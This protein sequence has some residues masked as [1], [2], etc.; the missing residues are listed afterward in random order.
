L[1]AVDTL[2][3]RTLTG[4][5]DDATFAAGLAPLR[6]AI[7][8][9]LAGWNVDRGLRTSDVYV[10]FA[11]AGTSSVGDAE[12]RRLEAIARAL[13]LPFTAPTIERLERVFATA[14]ASTGDAA[15]FHYVVE[16]DPAEGWADELSRWYDTEHMP[17]LAAVPGCVRAQR[18]CNADRTPSS[19]AGYDLTSP[20]VLESEAWLAVRHSAWS[21]R[22]RSQFRN[23]RRTMLRRLPLA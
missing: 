1:F 20:A 9:P 7:R 22:V 21:D 12:V 4:G 17:G 14:G 5:V 16:T 3:L 18:F 15:P 6:D 11:L 13:P 23:T 2:L 10:Y 8:I 19:H